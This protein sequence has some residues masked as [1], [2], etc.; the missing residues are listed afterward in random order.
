MARE[1]RQAAR[2][3]ER[4]ATDH[5]ARS[6]ASEPMLTLAPVSDLRPLVLV[7]NDDGVLAPGIVALASALRAK[8]RVVVCAP[9]T[10]QSAGSHALTLSRPLRHHA[11]AD[12]VHSVDGTPADC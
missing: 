8:F 5:N 9:A 7:S 10:E 12:D 6:H 1:M 2:R 11:L 3:R 4:V